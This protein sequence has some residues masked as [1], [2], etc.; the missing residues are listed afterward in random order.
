M[1]TDSYNQTNHKPIASWQNNITSD[2][3]NFFRQ[4]PTVASQKISRSIEENISLGN[5]AVAISLLNELIDRYPNSAINYNNRGLVY[6]RLARI[7][8]ALEDLDM[9]IAINPKLDSAYNNRA[10]CYAAGGNLVAAVADYD[11]AL[12]LNPANLRAWIN[13]GI[14]YRQMKAYDLALENFEIALFLG[15]SLKERIYAERGRTY[16]LQGDWNCAVADYQ[17]ALAMMFELPNRQ[18]EGQ[19]VRSWLDELLNPLLFGS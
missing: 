11:R 3:N 7:S 2:G 10:N 8:E 1:R 18:S 5:Y 4:S 16:H 12:D 15:N 6:F 13:Q 17:T 9:A 14:T 19:K